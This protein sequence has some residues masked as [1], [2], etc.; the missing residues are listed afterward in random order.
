LVQQDLGCLVVV[1][2]IQSQRDLGASSGVV[3]DLVHVQPPHD[4]AGQGGEQVVVDEVLGA[5][6]VAEGSQGAQQG[7]TAQRP[8]V[9]VPLL[10]EQGRWI[11]ASLQENGPPRGRSG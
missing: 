3:V 6:G 4:P 2:V 9:A 10:A 8:R 11:H 1:E 7:A 5:A